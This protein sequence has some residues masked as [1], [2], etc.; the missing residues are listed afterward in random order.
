MGC[1]MPQGSCEAVWAAPRAASACHPHPP[2]D[3]R[4]VRR[5]YWY[6]HQ[7]DDVVALSR[8]ARDLRPVGFAFAPAGLSWWLSGR[9]FT[10]KQ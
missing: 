2:R 3:Y 1:W 7:D 6:D 10:R 4:N 5:V 8:C 9:L